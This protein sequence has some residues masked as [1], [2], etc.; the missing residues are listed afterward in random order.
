MLYNLELFLGSKRAQYCIYCCWRWV[1]YYTV[2]G[3]LG[4]NQ[5]TGDLRESQTI[6]LDTAMFRPSRCRARDRQRSPLQIAA[7]A[8]VPGLAVTLAVQMPLLPRMTLAGMMPAPPHN[9]CCCSEVLLIL[10]FGP[11]D[12]C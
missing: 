10:R 1:L 9:G 8:A 5:A 4:F 6:A 2:M 7:A 11:N 3:G 12:A